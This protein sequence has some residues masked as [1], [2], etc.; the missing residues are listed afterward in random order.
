M[1]IAD[2]SVTG[3]IPVH[4]RA[5]GAIGHVFMALTVVVAILGIASAS[6][7]SA[8]AEVKSRYESLAEKKYWNAAICL[9]VVSKKSFGDNDREY[10]R[11]LDEAR[12]AIE[13]GDL[14]ARFGSAKQQAE[15]PDRA[16][17]TLV[18]EYN[19]LAKM[20]ELKAAKC[21]I[22]HAAE[23]FGKD[24]TP[25]AEMLQAIRRREESD[26]EEAALSLVEPRRMIVKRLSVS[27]L[28]IW[29]PG[30]ETCNA[31]ILLQLVKAT[32]DSDIW[33]DKRSAIL[34]EPS[35]QVLLIRAPRT[36]QDKIA[37]LIASI[38]KAPSE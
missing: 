14:P 15:D 28:P 20:G 19:E 30:A 26:N 5:I 27:D 8:R 13:Q 10:R 33:F 9:L 7:T 12:E 18:M 17:G 6:E 25:I 34:F 37:N 29:N 31:E 2:R 35:S 4:L 36:T 11:L 32:V 3:T 38:N 16:L 24:T 1:L 21:L 23:Q 22:D